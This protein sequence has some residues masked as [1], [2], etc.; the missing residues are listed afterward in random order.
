MLMCMSAVSIFINM[1]MYMFVCAV[2]MLSLGSECFF[3]MSRCV[4][5]CVCV[6]NINVK[7]MC[8]SMHNCTCVC[9]HV[10][11]CVYVCTCWCVHV[12]AYESVR[13]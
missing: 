9:M 8:V 6:H 12:C 3:L 11:V 7:L 2:H 13:R 5:V 1:C 10:C 4:S